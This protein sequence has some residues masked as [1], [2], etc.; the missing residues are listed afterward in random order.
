MA[1]YMFL[2][3]GGMPHTPVEME[4]HMHKWIVW[5]DELRAKGHLKATAP[6]ESN[7]GKVVSGKKK[8]VTD[9]PFAEA[10]DLV[11]GYSVIEARDLA[12]ATELSMGCPIFEYDGTV[13]VRTVLPVPSK[14]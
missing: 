10:K 8:A 1:E 9:G 5:M 13:E 3:R 7:N 2:F 11:G 6:L 14:R 12:H 4:T